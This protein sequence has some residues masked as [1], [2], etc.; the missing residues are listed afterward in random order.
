MALLY[1]VFDDTTKSPALMGNI[2]PRLI[3]PKKIINELSDE[4][5]LSYIN[6]NEYKKYGEILFC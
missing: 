2:K 6:P 3:M 4:V 5:T 1:L